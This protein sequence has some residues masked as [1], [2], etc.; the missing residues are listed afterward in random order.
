VLV[1]WLG[2]LDTFVEKLIQVFKVAPPG[3]VA[4]LIVGSLLTGILV[5][6]LVVRLVKGPVPGQSPPTPHPPASPSELEKHIARLTTALKST[7]ELWR[8]HDD[9][10]PRNLLNTIHTGKMKVVVLLN[11]KG[12]VSK[13]TLTA[14]IG[15]HYASLGMKVLLIDMDYQGSLTAMMLIAAGLTNSSSLVDSVVDTGDG[16]LVRQAAN[17]EANLGPIK[18]VSAGKSLH[19]I[20]NRV[21]IGRLIDPEPTRDVRFNLLHFLTS[22][23]VSKENFDVVLIDSPPRLT[24][25][26]INALAAASHFAIPTILDG[27]ATANVGTLLADTKSL[28]AYHLNPHL[29]LA[30]I[31]ATRTEAGTG[32]RDFE[33]ENKKLLIREAREKWGEGD[34]MLETFTPDRIDVAR[35]AG[36]ALPVLSGSESVAGPYRSV[37]KELADRIWGK[38]NWI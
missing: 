37:A 6:L 12:G 1:S 20:E 7:D 27:A 29:K 2:E 26:T 30:G 31:I 38:G 19:S 16:T 22:A 10:P 32:L 34:Y 23:E 3:A 25:G 28:F 13:T 36:S 9:A 15:A 17:L 33:V 14:N 4:V 5:T 35:M 21:Q 18:L 24:T 11:L 8:F